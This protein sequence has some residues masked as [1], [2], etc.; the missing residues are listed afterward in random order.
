MSPAGDPLEPCLKAQ[1]G[2]DGIV[3]K[4][5]DLRHV[6]RLVDT[7]ARRGATVL[8][9][10]ETG[11]GKELVAR[12]IHNRSHR[13]DRP[14]V[15]VNC[16]AIPAVSSKA[17]SL[18][19]SAGPLRAQSTTKFAVCAGLGWSRTHGCRRTCGRSEGNGIHTRRQKESNRSY[20]NRRKVRDCGPSTR[21]KS[22][23]RAIALARSDRASGSEYYWRNN[24]A[25][26]LRSKR[27]ACC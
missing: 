1:T 13:K 10:G 12:A 17:N 25:D 2:F 9:L 14:F 20:R 7:V 18:A 23:E 15:K 16:A 4:S 22:S 27:V 5:A 6:L 24:C 21:A 8:L 11:T 3:G 19:M 26:G